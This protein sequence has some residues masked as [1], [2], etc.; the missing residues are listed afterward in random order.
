MCRVLFMIFRVSH[1]RRLSGSEYEQAMNHEHYIRYAISLAQKAESQ[2]EVPVGA[3]IVKNNEIIAEG[4]NQPI[5]LNDPTAH[6]EMMALRAAAKKLNN[7]RLTDCVMYVTLE[8]CSMCVG[9]MIH[10]RISHLVFGASEPKTGAAGSA[11]HLLNDP[12]HNHQID[13]H[14]GVLAQECASILKNFFQNK[15]LKNAE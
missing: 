14:G 12:K 7:Y 1:R 13:C 8:P 9:A 4:Y 15:R 2:G 11:F 5:Q 6:A 3:V 10:A